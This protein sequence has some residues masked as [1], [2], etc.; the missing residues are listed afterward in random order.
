ME[1]DELVGQAKFYDRE[2]LDCS[3]QVASIQK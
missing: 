3:W 1:K 2:E